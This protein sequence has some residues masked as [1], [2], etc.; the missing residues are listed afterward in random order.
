MHLIVSAELGRAASLQAPR[1]AG[2]SA[3]RTRDSKISSDLST[4]RNARVV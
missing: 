1:R 2:Y 3:T 4:R